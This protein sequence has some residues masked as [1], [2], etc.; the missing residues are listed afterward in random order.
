MSRTKSEELTASA[1]VA[2]IESASRLL[3]RTDEVKFGHKYVGMAVA[4]DTLIVYKKSITPE[5]AA[6]A[7]TVLEKLKHDGREGLDEE[8]H[9]ALQ[10]AIEVL[11]SII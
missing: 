9:L 2:G 6:K 3:N 5:G 1:I 8:E 11:T 4:Q 7:I 10:I